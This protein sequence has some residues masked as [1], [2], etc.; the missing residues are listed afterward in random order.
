M[1]IVDYPT[2]RLSYVPGSTRVPDPDAVSLL[3]HPTMGKLFDE[4]F[5]RDRRGGTVPLAMLAAFLEAKI[6]LT[7][8]TSTLTST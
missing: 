2:M 1:G 8:V 4:G 5:H 3:N 6:A 7:K